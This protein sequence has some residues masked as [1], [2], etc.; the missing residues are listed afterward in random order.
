MS[1]LIDETVTGGAFAAVRVPAWHNLGVTVQENVKA[2]DLLRLAHADFP[3]LR[4][5]ARL[6]ELVPLDES[7]NFTVRYEA[8]DTRNTLI[9][10]VHPET[11]E[12]QVLGVASAGYPL[13]TPAET[14][15]GFGDAIMGQGHMR[16]ATAGVL[17]EGRQVFMSFELPEELVL[18]GGDPAKLYLTVSTSFDQSTASAARISAVRVVCANTLEAARQ[19]A[20]RE[21]VF[22]KTSRLDIQALQA[23]SALELVPE[24]MALLKV[25]AEQLLSVKVTDAK[26]LEIIE[27]LWA[28]NEDAGKAK[29]T[30]WENRRDSLMEL[31]ATAPTQEFG[32]HTGWAAVNAVTEDRDWFSM[33][34]GAATEEQKN[35]ARF[36]RSIGLS[37]ST[38]I[39]EPK[40]AMAQR[41]LALV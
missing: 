24:Y 9:Y 1:H 36:A 13:L 34:K 3:I 15:I 25:E 39:I 14:L 40:R 30:R 28:P 6:N 31:F 12:A 22:R 18:G 11:G 17:D 35:T 29:V 5:A 20:K 7:G 32:R 23:K 8:V 33:V 16:S 26:F 41:V 38:G 4:G 21:I 10:R 37:P 2:L 19:A 27:G